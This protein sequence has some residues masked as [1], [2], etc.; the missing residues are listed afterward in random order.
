MNDPAP[1]RASL[2]SSLLKRLLRTPAITAQRGLEMARSFVLLSPPSLRLRAWRMRR[3][4]PPAEIRAAVVAHIYYPELFSEIMETFDQLPPGSR[5]LITAPPEQAAS[6]K[7]MADGRSEIEIYET[8][9]RG[10]DIAPFLKLLNDGALD[11]FDAVLKI[12]SK[13]SPHLSYGSLR[14]RVFFFGLAGSAG[15]VARIL[16][17]FRDP[18]VGFIG[19]SSYFRTRSFYWMENRQRVE[20]LCQ[21]MGTPPRMGF[22][23]GSM[24]WVR[25]AALAPLK[26][27]GLKVEDFESEAGQLDG[28]LH[29]AIE[30]CF[31]LSGLA[32][33]YEVRST[34]GRRLLAPL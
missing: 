12:H 18:S 24:F 6:L 9:N 31:V 29:H 17:Q 1:H 13:K 22:F 21:R 20:L 8:A 25:P 34:A 7:H 3:V 2:Q 32:A 27:I 19:L 26:R 30:R 23:E 14:R 4:S 10:R 16:N 5:L 28:T 33:G 11:R 15:N